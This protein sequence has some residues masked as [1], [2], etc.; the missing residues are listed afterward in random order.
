MANTKQGTTDTHMTSVSDQLESAWLS[1]EM[2]YS[3]ACG[4][5]AEWE[6]SEE[7]SD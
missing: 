7:D 1:G 4:W 5:M 2:S 3:E 6:S